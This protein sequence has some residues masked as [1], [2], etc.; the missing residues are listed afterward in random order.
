[1]HQLRLSFGILRAETL[2]DTPIID[3]DDCARYLSI[4]KNELSA[5][6]PGKKLRIFLYRVD[7]RKHARCRMS[8]KHRTIHYSHSNIAQ[9]TRGVEVRT[10]LADTILN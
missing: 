7:Q 6:A 1:L 9:A 5:S 2:P 4:A 8:D 3:L 10:T